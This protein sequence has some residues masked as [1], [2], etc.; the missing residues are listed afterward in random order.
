MVFVRAGQMVRYSILPQFLDPSNPTVAL[1]CLV[2]EQGSYATGGFVA[3]ASLQTIIAENVTGFKV[4]LSADGGRTWAGQG[5]TANDFATGWTTGILA[6]VN[7]QLTSVG[8]PSA[9]NAS[10]PNWFRETP[11]MVR[12]DL[13]TRSAVKRVENAA[14]ANTVDYRERLQTLYMVP[15][16]FGL[17]LK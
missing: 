6:Q 16:H 7:T 15:R 11:L 2:R 14:V 8:L 12:V 3:D 5:L 13:T 10:D 9:A 1:P 17:S 4:F